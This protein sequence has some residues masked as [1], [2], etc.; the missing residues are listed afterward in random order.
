MKDLGIT[1]GAWEISPDN[2]WECCILLGDQE[3]HYINLENRNIDGWDQMHANAELICDAGN[4]AQKCGLLPSELLKQRDELR[5]ALIS[6]LWQFAY[7]G[8]RDGIAVM[9]TG[10]LS[11]LE[12]AFSALDISDPIPVTDFEAAIKSTE[13]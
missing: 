4:T 10:G 7:Y 9:H 5:E 1:P 11:A 3:D 8:T 13:Q 2:N 6:M 12:D